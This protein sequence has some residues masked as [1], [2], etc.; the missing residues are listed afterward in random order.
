VGAGPDSDGRHRHGLGD[1]GGQALGHAFQYQGEDSALV[2]GLRF[3][4][5][6]PGVLLGPALDPVAAH[7]VHGLRR[8]AEVAHDGDP[9]IDQRSRQLEQRAFELDRVRTSLFEEPPGVADPV[10]DGGVIGHERHVAHDQGVR[11]AAGHRPGV[12]QHLLHRDRQRRGVPQDVLGQR[13]A[14]QDDGHAG[15]VEDLGGGEVVRGEHD[16][17]LAALLEL[18]EIPDGEGHGARA[19]LQ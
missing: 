8:Q 15:L 18:P 12:V 2:H 13:V 10:L 4:K 1:L 17:S 6:A 16:E 14:D 9:P 11:R 3:I 7:G 5:Q 19:S